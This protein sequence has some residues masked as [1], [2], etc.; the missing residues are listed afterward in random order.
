MKWLS[1]EHATNYRQD[2]DL[3]F[4]KPCLIFINLLSKDYFPFMIFYVFEKKNGGVFFPSYGNSQ[5]TIVNAPL[6][7]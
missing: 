2:L 1:Q 5:Y 3:F 7:K 6:K 4:F